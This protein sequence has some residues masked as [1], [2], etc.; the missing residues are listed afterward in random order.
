MKASRSLVV[1]AAALGLS[2]AA[3][4]GSATPQAAAAVPA[5]VVDVQA[6][7]AE[8]GTIEAALELSGNLAPRARVGV[9]P[10]VPGA[11]ERL[12]VDIGTPV[13]EGQTVATIDRREID[14]LFEKARTQA[15]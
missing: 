11:I 1:L 12:L 4:G 14:A 8:A 6:V 15:Y 5:P 2:S 3:C 10:R 9:K 13:R 7:K